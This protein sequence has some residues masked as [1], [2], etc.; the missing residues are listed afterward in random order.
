MDIDEQILEWPAIS[1]NH[2]ATLKDADVKV[3]L[4]EHVDS[5]I[6]AA[7]STVIHFAVVERLSEPCPALNLKRHSPN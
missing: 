2:N 7:Y 3:L 6:Q 4:Q 5:G 1:E